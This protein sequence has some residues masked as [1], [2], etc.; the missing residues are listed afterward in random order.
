[1]NE[2]DVVVVGGGAAGLSAALVLTR[3]RRRVA[4]V[5][6][7]QPRNAPAAH[8][9]GFLGSDGLPPAELL[10]AGR[11]EVAGYGGQLISGTVT[12]IVPRGRADGAAL[13]RRA[14]EVAARGRPGAA[15]PAR[16]GHDRAARRDPRHPRRPRALGPRP[17]AL[18]VLPRLRG[19][20]PAPRRARRHARGRRRT[21]TSSGSG[22]TTSCS[23]ANGGT[24]T[25]DQR[26]QLVA[27]AIGIVDEPVTRLVVEDDRLT[28]VELEAG[29]V[30]PADRRVRPARSSCPTTTCSLGL[31]CATH[32][33]GWVA[34]DAT[35]RTSVAGVWAAGNAVNPRAQVITAAGEG[36]AA[37]IAINNDLVEEDLPIAVTNFRL[38]LPR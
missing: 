35:G 25:V 22:P 30:V 33:N 18:P 7:G 13:N 28:G 24:L 5:D 17:A 32:D 23:S 8:M 37:A 6:A 26:E 2:Y 31:G 20:R 3:A 10:A 14:F 36:S 16:P 4:V 27:R 29:Q 19:P 38:G 11:D 15:R 34:V 9:Q 1:M 12:D 21:P